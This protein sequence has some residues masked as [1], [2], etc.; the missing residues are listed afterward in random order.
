MHQLTS[1]ASGQGCFC[2]FLLLQ[3][4]WSS[5]HPIILPLF[6]LIG[7]NWCWWSQ[8]FQGGG[9]RGGEEASVNL[10]RAGILHDFHIKN[11]LLAV[12][13][14]WV[15]HRRTSDEQTNV[16]FT[17]FLMKGILWSA[18]EKHGWLLNLCDVT[19]FL[20]TPAW[21]HGTMIPS[22]FMGKLRGGGKEVAKQH[23]QVPQK[24][25]G[26]FS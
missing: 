10:Q 19:T 14:R 9:G 25:E 2:G 13:A 15:L 1:W 26:E 23:K 7:C 4:T 6:I 17:I 16:S 8:N 21:I 3:S 18:L 20:L 11:D 5:V 24:M 22:Q 12:A